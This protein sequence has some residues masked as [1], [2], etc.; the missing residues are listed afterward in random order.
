MKVFGGKAKD[1]NAVTFE[2]VELNLD[3]DFGGMELPEVCTAGDATGWEWKCGFHTLER[4]KTIQDIFSEE[5][6]LNQWSH[7]R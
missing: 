4:E 6:D 1:N 3:T 5:M 7:V 2:V